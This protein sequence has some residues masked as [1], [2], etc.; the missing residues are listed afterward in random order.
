MKRGLLIFFMALSISSYADIMKFKAHSFSFRERDEDTYEWM[1]WADWQDDNSLIVFDESTD[2]ITIY[3]KHKERLDAIDYE[4]EFED[5]DQGHNI[6][7]TCID[8]NGE[9][10]RFVVRRTKDK[11]I[12]L[13]FRYSDR[14]CVYSVEWVQ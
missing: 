13:Y 5:D 3:G 8:S 10:C 2:V 1:S 14:Q 6:P 9:E 11:S 4:S 7:I 12:Q